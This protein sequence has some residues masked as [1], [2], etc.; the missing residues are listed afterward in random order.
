MMERVQLS[1]SAML[2]R[3]GKESIA[4]LQ[5]RGVESTNAR[6]VN[7]GL[8]FRGFGRALDLATVPGCQVVRPLSA[9]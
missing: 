4:T 8:D 5:T 9:L 6:N 2:R 1:E 7:K 3:E